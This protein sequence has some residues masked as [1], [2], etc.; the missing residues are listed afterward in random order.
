MHRHI[1]ILLIDM[2]P[3][4]LQR[5]IVEV[6]ERLEA[7][8]LFQMHFLEETQA[9]E[10]KMVTTVETIFSIKPAPKRIPAYFKNFENLKLKRVK[11]QHQCSLFSKIYYRAHTYM[12][13]APTM[14]KLQIYISSKF[15]TDD[16]DDS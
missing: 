8:F 14:S 9:I 11:D 12:Y 13:N 10:E 7:L 3:W 4:Y 15:E 1:V 6:I 5:L 16:E 2:R